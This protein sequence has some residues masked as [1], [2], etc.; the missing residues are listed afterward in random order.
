[1]AAIGHWQNQVQKCGMQWKDTNV[2]YRSGKSTSV[3]VG[4]A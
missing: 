3:E 2:M 1:V 4:G